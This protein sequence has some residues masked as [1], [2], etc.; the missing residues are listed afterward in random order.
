MGRGSNT[1]DDTWLTT[2]LYIDCESNRAWS[3]TKA[4]YEELMKWKTRQHQHGFTLIELMIVVAI[5][6]ILAVLAIVGV[7]RYLRNA[8]EAEARNTIGTVSKNAAEALEREKMAGTWVAPGTSVASS[9]GFCTTSN[10]VPPAVTPAGK[11]TS[12]AADWDQGKVPTV[13]WFCL[14]F[15]MSEPQYYSYLYTATS[16][17]TTDKDTID[18]D[19]FGDL[20]GNT[21][22]SRFRMEG[23]IAGG[24]LKYAPT[25]DETDPDE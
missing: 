18:I 9:R 22:T 5:I 20:D 21:K 2:E 25:I 10:M 11:Y 7:T 15:Q 3:G 24:Q 4:V 23:Q 8:K 19:A 14:K 13:G 17:G 6:G 12:A 16:T 1:H